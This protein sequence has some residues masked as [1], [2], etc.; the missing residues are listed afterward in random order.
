V[1]MGVSGSGKSTV[2]ALLASELGWDF[3][4]ADDYHSVENVEKM[5]KG[6]P[7]TDADREPWLETLRARIVEWME[8][9]KNGVLACS[10]LR[11]AY[12][13]RLRVNDQVRFVYLKGERDLLSERLLQ[14]PGHYMK[15][16]MLESQLSTLEEPLDAVTVSANSTPHEIVRKIR[17]NLALA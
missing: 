15:Q 3:A 5:R 11:Q 6:M 16:P 4:D 8:A 1:L 13:D 12:R 2:G 17:E 7:L 9:G 10:A 14:R